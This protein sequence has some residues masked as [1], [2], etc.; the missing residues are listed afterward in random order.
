[1]EFSGAQLQ[2]ETQ[3]SKLLK[4]RLFS[5]VHTGRHGEV[6]WKNWCA[7]AR[8]IPWVWIGCTNSASKDG[9]CLHT[10]IFSPCWPEESWQR[11]ERR[12]RCWTARRHIRLQS[13]QTT[14]SVPIC[15]CKT[16]SVV[17]G[18]QWRQGA[19]QV[20]S[21]KKSHTSRKPLHQTSGAAEQGHHSQGH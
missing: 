2:R 7:R 15:H 3:S 19:T 21:A 9:G 10:A 14:T 17:P 4:T 20:W 6:R 11:S 16:E 5:G 18:H 1:M 12:S 8:T 13:G